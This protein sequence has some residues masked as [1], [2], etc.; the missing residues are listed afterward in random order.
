MRTINEGEKEEKTDVKR[1]NKKNNIFV[2]RNKVN[3]KNGIHSING[4]FL[5]ILSHSKTTDGETHRP[6]N[7]NR[8]VYFIALSSDFDCL[9]YKIDKNEH[10]YPSLPFKYAIDCTTFI[11]F[12]KNF[13]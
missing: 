2:V 3:E 1:I 5:E 10:L 4:G 7:K 6:E 13:D 12:R 8:C 11:K 9:L